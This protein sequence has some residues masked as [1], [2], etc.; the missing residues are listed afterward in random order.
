MKIY[1]FLSG[2]GG[3]GVVGDVGV[4]GVVGDVGVWLGLLFCCL[5]LERF[6]N[7]SAQVAVYFVGRAQERLAP[8]L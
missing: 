6:H 5:L 2:V 3:F 4:V 7:E 1:G 8:V